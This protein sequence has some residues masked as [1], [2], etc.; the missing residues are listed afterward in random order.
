MDPEKKA[1]L[2]AAGFAVVDT[3]E[4]LID[5]VADLSKCPSCGGPADNGHDR[6]L[7]PS[8]YVCTRCEAD[9]ARHL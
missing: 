5:Q 3:P 9:Y 2:E 4:A 6:C 7:P 1:R 8:P